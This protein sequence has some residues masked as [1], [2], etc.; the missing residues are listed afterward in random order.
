MM[1]KEEDEN[2]EMMLKNET[3]KNHVTR[4]VNFELQTF[5]LL[6]VTLNSYPFYRVFSKMC[7]CRRTCVPLES[8]DDKLYYDFSSD[9]KKL[10]QSEPDTVWFQD[11]F[12]TF[13]VNFQPVF[14]E[15][16]TQFAM[17]YTFNI[18]D[19]DKLLNFKS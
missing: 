1:F 2:L 12:S 18:I 8:Y 17:S 3:F 9:A 10:M 15:I 5:Q 14:A 19:A 6:I 7:S 13:N 16:R 4:F 11:Q